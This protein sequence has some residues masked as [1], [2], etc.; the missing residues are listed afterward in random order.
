MTKIITIIIIVSTVWSVISGL[1]EKHKRDKLASKG[2][3]LSRRSQLKQQNLQVSM[4]PQTLAE[5]F[6]ARINALRQKPPT[7]VVVPKAEIVKSAQEPSD[8]RIKSI[9]SLHQ[10]DCPLPP[11]QRVRHRQSR[12]G[13]FYRILKT[14]RGIRTAVIL[15]EVLGKPVS[16]R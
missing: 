12:A 7:R 15:S 16:Q 9:K 6:D 10:E 5:L 14:P 1:I 3:D 13:A 11:K 4:Q 8:T 2:G